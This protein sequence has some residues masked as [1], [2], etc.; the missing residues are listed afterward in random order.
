MQDKTL[1]ILDGSSLVY[2][3]FYAI[4]LSTSKG[5]PTGAVYG[6][7]NTLKKIREHFKPR[8]M[9]ICFDISRKTHRQEKF[10]EYKIQRPEMPDPLKIQIPKVKELIKYFGIRYVEKA[11]YEADDLIYYFALKAYKKGWHATIITSDKDMY[12]LIRGNRVC[13]YNPFKDKLYDN[14]SFREEFGF[15]PS[16]IVDYLSLTGD[17]V[18]NIPG[19]K[20]IG[21][22]G[23]LKLIKSF[24]TIDN[25]FNSL[26][27]VSPKMKA[28][29]ESNKENIFLSKELI[30][31]MSPPEFSYKLDELK[32]ENP[33]YKSVYRICQELELKSFIKDIPAPE[34]NIKINVE[35]GTSSL[36]AR[37][38]KHKA[39]VAFY[40]TDGYYF[41]LDD[42]SEVV[43]KTPLSEAKY[44]LED[45]NIRKIS[46]DFKKIYNDDSLRVALKSLWFDVKIAAYLL[47]PS[48][49]DY[50]LNNLCSQ[51]LKTYVRDIPPQ[52]CPYF[53][54]KLYVIFKDKISKQGMDDLFFNIE[55]PLSRVLADMEK[56]GVMIDKKS[57]KE[58]NKEVDL[59]INNISK[60][61][62]KIAKQE[63][64]LNSPK[65]LRKVLFEELGLP[66]Q[67]KTKTGYSTDEEVLNK[68]SREFPV[69]KLLLEYRQFSKLKSTYLIPFIRQADNPSSKIH[70]SFNQTAT[71]TGRL[72]SSSP[73]LQNIPIRED[74]AQRIR[75]VFISSFEGGYILSSDYSQIE[76]RVLAHFSGEDAL[77]D[78]F[79]NDKDIHLHTA[80]ILFGIDPQKISKKERN[81]AKRVN[82]GIIYGMSSYGLARELNITEN[83][84]RSFI[85]DYFSRYPKVKKFIDSIIEEAHDNGYVKTITGRI[86][87]LPD[88]NSQNRDLKEFSFRQAI[89]T[90]IQGTAA[91]IIKIAMVNIYRKF[92]EEG[93][94]SKLIL[95]VHDELVFDVNKKELKKVVDI[96]KDNMENSIN[97]VVPLVANLKIGKNWLELSPLT[98]NNDI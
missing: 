42:D 80:S 36:L 84:A 20:G 81:I 9:A 27:K 86:R 58:L 83:E 45:E 75:K 96:V 41:F 28:V 19:A 13:V 69:A 60:E 54:F 92:E 37:I 3:S 50:S 95:Q 29:L 89:N 82:F 79:R 48:L 23:A 62:F 1:Y 34:L 38:F 31:L 15:L 65:Q 64:N 94:S 76:L 57:L 43:Y 53:I 5:F 18:D 49:G 67:K 71:Q 2:R 98:P 46:Y 91:D 26:D 44:I 6:F 90:P 63:F 11:G 77:L 16:R 85:N 66:P 73:N 7:L 32:I 70:A 40:K 72:S 33:D 56:T 22:V 47:N 59:N 97:L 78:A 17:N 52:A 51:F 24:G 68:L 88:I 55:I 61:I 87:Y 8:Y 39:E 12:Q 4:S 14:D 21:K 25:I 74:F 10:K 93:I 35:E 30:K